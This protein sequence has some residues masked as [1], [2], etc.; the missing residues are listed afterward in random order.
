MVFNYLGTSSVEYNWI[1]KS[2]NYE[3]QQTVA[4]Y[5]I[6]NEHSEDAKLFAKEAIR[7]LIAGGDVDFI[8]PLETYNFQSET[9]ETLLFEQDYK[10]RMTNAEKL[11]FNN[12]TMFQQLDYLHSSYL[13]QEY[14]LVYFGDSIHVQYNGK[15]DAYRHALWNAIGAAKLG[16]NLMKQLSDA[17]E[18]PN[19]GQTNNPLEEE[20]DLYNNNVG[21]NIGSHSSIMLMMKVKFA[22]D[23]G[24]TKYIS[25]TY[26]NGNIIPGF[27]QIIP[28]NQ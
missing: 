21:R 5:L 18:V 10:N 25:P 12:L 22:V 7:A 14:A 6:N 15:G 23:K 16:T 8:D 28:T 24:D 11:I 1:M 13:A 26:G 4:E 20:M 9:T 19:E 2:E 17:H 27:S 3:D